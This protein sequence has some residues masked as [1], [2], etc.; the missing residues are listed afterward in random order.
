[1]M[2]FQ[3]VIW[4]S[5]IGLTIVAF[6]RLPPIY[7]LT[8]LLLLLPAYLSNRSQSLPRYVLI[9]FPAFVAMAVMAK[10]IVARRVLLAI[11]LPLLAFAT[12]L[13]TNGFWVA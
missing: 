7:G 13:F 12:F 3:A 6:R 2:I 5:F 11:M 4:I 1:M 9:G 8:V 10:P